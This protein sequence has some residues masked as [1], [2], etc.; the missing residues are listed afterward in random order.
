MAVSVKLPPPPVLDV[1]TSETVVVLTT[2][3]D[4]PVMVTVVVLA[5]VAEVVVM[6]RADVTGDPPGVTD[7]G[8]KLHAAPVGRLF[9]QVRAT[10]LVKPFDGVTVTV[11]VAELP[12]VIEAGDSAV[13]PTVKLG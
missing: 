2:E 6:V 5:G 3:P 9:E 11:E 10:A 12:A 8:L 4:V 1:T 13:A 7:A